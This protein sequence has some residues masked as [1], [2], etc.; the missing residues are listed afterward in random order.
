MR[1]TAAIVG[2][3][4]LGWCVLGLQVPP[5]HADTP[6]TIQIA[7]PT[8]VTITVGSHRVIFIGKPTSTSPVA[9]APGTPN[10]QT[11][12][13]VEPSGGSASQITGVLAF[14][15]HEIP[16]GARYQITGGPSACNTEFKLYTA[17]VE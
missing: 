3:V 8:N 16:N 11:V 2:A 5:A 6:G 4:M 10:P 1:A 15:D 17:T 14:H 12:V 13:A 9:C 7:I